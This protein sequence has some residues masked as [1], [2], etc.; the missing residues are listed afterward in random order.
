[1]KAVL[2]LLIVL[3]IMAAFC[4]LYWK[5]EKTMNK[6]R[7]RIAKRMVI[8]RNAINQAY[9]RNLNYTLPNH[10]HLST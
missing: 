4:L 5:V 9:L 7:R 1:M 2:S 8:K 10:T 3:A 6:V